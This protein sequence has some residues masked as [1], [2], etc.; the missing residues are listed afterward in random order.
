MRSLPFLR[1]QTRPRY[2]EVVA[3]WQEKNLANVTA[4]DLWRGVQE[5]LDAAMDFIG[6]IMFAT[7]GAAA[8]SEGLF[9]R[10]YDKLAR[11]EGDPAAPAFLMGYDSIPV[12]A[13]KSL[14]D[15]AL[16]CRERKEL[17][18]HLLAT[19]SEKIVAQMESGQPIA[20]V[21]ANDW[22]AMREHLE[23]HLARFG[24]LIYQLDFAEPLPRDLPG[25]ALEIV[26]MYLRGEGAN[27]HER[28][29]AS[30]VRRQQAT[31][32]LLSRT[33]GLKRWALEKALAWAQPLSEAREDALADI[34]LGYPILRQILRELGRRLAEA[35]AVERVDDIFWLERG[36]V[37]ASVE[38]LAGGQSL[39]DFAPAIGERKAFWKKMKAVTPPPVLP[40]TTKRYMGV[41]LDIITPA[42]DADRATGMLKGV[43]T[44]AG[45]IT[46][47]ACVIHGPEDFGQMK[48]GAVLVA[49]T[50]TPAWTPL[51]AM[52]SAV[53]T[54]IGGPLSHGSIVAREY[55]IPAVMGTGVATRRIHSGQMITVDG[56]TGVVTLSKNG[57]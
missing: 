41:S 16:W 25:L 23:Q 4:P 34:G 45:K 8:G 13:E 55:G 47:S 37:A 48:P 10:L 21:T 6:T 3:D 18:D 33:K 40:T 27:P 42:S 14:Y 9:T 36:E 1:S 2:L 43:P 29:Q 54:D 38:R 12:Q 51:F 53:V 32:A 52:A 35:G 19:P 17:V 49:G 15:L 30:Q 56:S 24:H 11:R 28:Q 57:K 39:S 31:Q 26:K 20:Q 46:A 44:S 22:Q 50:T 5:V 7:A